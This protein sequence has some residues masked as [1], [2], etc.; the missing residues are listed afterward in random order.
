MIKTTHKDIIHDVIAEKTDARSGHKDW[1]PYYP[2]ALTEVLEGLSEEELQEAEETL[3]KWNA[4][5]PPIE[6]QRL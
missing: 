6:V 2:A 3:E 5:G 4:E 1:L